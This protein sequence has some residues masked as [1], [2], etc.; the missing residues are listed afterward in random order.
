M[1]S[2]T[3]ES[4]RADILVRMPPE[5]KLRV[6]KAANEDGMSV[7]DWLLDGIEQL[8]AFRDAEVAAGKRK[9]DL[10][11]RRDQKFWEIVVA[12]AGAAT[13]GDITLSKADAQIELEERATAAIA[14]W[15]ERTTAFYHAEPRTPLE[16]LC[17]E[18]EDLEVEIEGVQ[19]TDT[20]D[21]EGLAGKYGYDP[22]DPDGDEAEPDE[23]LFDDGDLDESGE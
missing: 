3:R 5:L 13:L 7:N 4:G 23:A 17:K 10:E 1:T 2:K 22:D 19:Q 9:A 6:T 8:L 12:M 18:H 20:F 11:R 14:K 21:D 16:R 15:R